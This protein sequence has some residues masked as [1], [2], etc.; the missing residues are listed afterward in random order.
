MIDLFVIVFNDDGLPYIYGRATEVEITSS[1][2][3]KNSELNE[4]VMQ[5]LQF[6]FY[7]K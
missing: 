4:N 2:N 5:K 6:P 3:Q 1:L 7:K